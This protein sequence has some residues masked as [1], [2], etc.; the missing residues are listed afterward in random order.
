MDNFDNHKASGHSTAFETNV[1]KPEASVSILISDGEKAR[2]PEQQSKVI[3]V[4]KENIYF[5]DEWKPWPSQD[6]DSLPIQVK[7]CFLKW[8]DEH[9]DADPSSF[10]KFY[11]HQMQKEQEELREYQSSLRKEYHEFKADGYPGTFADFLAE[12][13]YIPEGF[14]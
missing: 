6:N 12:E 3:I 5:E 14:C 13:V 4:D 8:K 11:N 9:P 7:S 2:W 1:S 10:E